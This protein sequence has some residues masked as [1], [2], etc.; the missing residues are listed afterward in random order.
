M[1]DYIVYFIVGGGV[2]VLMSSII[3]PAIINSI[4]GE[5]LRLRQLKELIEKN[6]FNALMLIILMCVPVVIAASILAP[7]D[8]KPLTWVIIMGL[9]LGTINA[10]QPSAAK[11]QKK[12]KVKQ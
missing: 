3:I 6:R 9:F 7:S 8:E 1:K 11:K 5:V 10:F 12:K 2:A 4:L